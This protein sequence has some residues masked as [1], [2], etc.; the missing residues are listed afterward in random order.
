M[1]KTVEQT[2]LERR[3]VRRY[4][5]DAIPQEDV[6]FIYEAIRNT[7]TSYNGQQFSVVDVADQELK[8]KLYALTGQ[9]QIKTCNRFLIFCA[10]Y[11]KITL[12]AKSKN[13]P[14][15]VFPATVDGYTVGVI[16][17]SLAMMSALTAAES[18]GLGTCPIGYV[19]TA[20]PAQV[21]E[22]LLLPENVTVVCGLAIGVP[23]E[24]PDMKPKQPVDLVIHHNVYGSG[25]MSQ[26]L[27]DYDEKVSHYNRTRE[28]TKS[29][30]DWVSHIVGYYHEGSGYDMLHAVRPHG[31]LTENS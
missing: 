7:P 17:A 30:N 18:R 13:V 31:F 19:R 23:R 5:R 9:K 8:E 14:V 21:A 2:L 22:L 3:S 12:A 25:D 26:A 11:R 6:D 20:A 24:L 16:D 15:G 10:D 4:T 28:G 29:D 1:S 27:M